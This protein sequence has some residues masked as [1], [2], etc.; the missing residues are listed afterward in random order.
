MRMD[1]KTSEVQSHEKWTRADKINFVAAAA[2]CIGLALAVGL[3]DFL[4]WISYL[5]RPQASISSPVNNAKIPNNT[6]GADG[7]AEHIPDNFD[8]WLIVRSEIGGQWYPIQRLRVV[9]GSWQVGQEKICPTEGPEQLEIFLVPDTGE[10]Q[11]F[12]SQSSNALPHSRGITS[13]PPYSTIEAI[14]NIE[15]TSSSC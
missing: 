5:E 8:L 15:V 11:L 4:H 9:N 6:F 14:S 7:S 3:P 2:A 13:L 1:D 12:N 10:E